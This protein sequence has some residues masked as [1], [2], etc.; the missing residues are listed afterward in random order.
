MEEEKDC[1]HCGHFVKH[2]VKVNQF[3]VEANCGHCIMGVSLKSFRKRNGKPHESC[4][5][6]T[7]QANKKEERRKN[8]KEVLRDMEKSL[9][10][11]RTILKSDED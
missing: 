8:I 4:D 9:S 2:Y 11:I 10:D 6:W 1:S 3:L 5:N 7:P